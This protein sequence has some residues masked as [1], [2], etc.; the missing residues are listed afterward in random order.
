MSQNQIGTPSWVDLASPDLDASARFYNGLFGWDAVET[1]PVEET[2]GYRMF[3]LRD[4]LVAGLGPLQGEGQPPAWTIYVLVS[5]A[6]ETSERV[7]SAG[8]AVVLEPLDV[9]DAGRM[10]VFG[11]TVGAFIAVWQPGTHGG[12][13]ILGEPG[14]LC[15]SE[16]ATRDPD[17]ARSFY[18][19]VFD[20]APNEVEMEGASYTEWRLGE[21]AVGGMIAMDER[22][23][24][25]LPSHW[26]S[27]F[28]V[29]DC[30]ASAKLAGDLGGSVSVPPTDIP[31]GRFSVL[32]DP[33]GAFFSII[34]MSAAA[35]G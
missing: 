25:E 2:G 26:M 7:R 30:D 11:D 10:A 8:G 33:H 14:S 15:W 17:A 16:L 23:P 5:D 29:D 31:A 3:T 9:L 13:Q 19:A 21:R 22:W 35:A 28:A 12:A 6:D 27:Y 18:G 32:S 24:A 20:W 34:R 4:R 1:G